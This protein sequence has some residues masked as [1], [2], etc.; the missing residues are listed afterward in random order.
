MSKVDEEGS[1][2]FIALIEDLSGG[3][4]CQPDTLNLP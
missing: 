4:E 3:I 2:K 1:L